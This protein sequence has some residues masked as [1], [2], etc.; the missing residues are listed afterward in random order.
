MLIQEADCCQNKRTNTDI[1]PVVVDGSQFLGSTG[2]DKIDPLGDIELTGTLEVGSIGLDERLGGNVLDSSTRHL[3]GRERERKLDTFHEL[4][5][6]LN[7]ANI[8]YWF[9]S[10]WF[11]SVVGWVGGWVDSQ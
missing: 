7:V 10:V 5:E 6:L 11:G 3:M 2:L 9:G 1:E 8:V 4:I